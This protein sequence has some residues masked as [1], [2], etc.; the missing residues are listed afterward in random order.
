MDWRPRA[1][2]PGALQADRR[3]GSLCPGL[4]RAAG[5]SPGALPGVAGCPPLTRAPLPPS[6]PP[7]TGRRPR[8]WSPS[9]TNCSSSCPSWKVSDRELGVCSRCF[10]NVNGV[11]WDRG[12]VNLKNPVIF[13]GA[14]LRDLFE[15]VCCK[16]CWAVG[17]QVLQGCG[18]MRSI[19]GR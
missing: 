11:M 5:A 6:R 2:E 18:S 12:F 14:V 1:G 8:P 4:G 19:K 15:V 16:V 3:A 10:L 9:P 17:L 13:A 7:P